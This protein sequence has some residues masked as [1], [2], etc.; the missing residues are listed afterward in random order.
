MQLV[1]FDPG[2]NSMAWSHGFR[3]GRVSNDSLAKTSSNS[4]R[5]SRTSASAFA[6]LCAA[7]ASLC[8]VVALAQ[9]CSIFGGRSTYSKWSPSVNASSGPR[10]T[11]LGLK[12][13]TDS[14]LKV[15][16]DSDLKVGMDSNLK[17]EQSWGSCQ[18]QGRSLLLILL[19][20][21]VGVG[22]SGTFV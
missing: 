12:V 18:D 15:G 9:M 2:S 13:G 20:K 16:M 7:S 6:Y 11:T 4:H 21:G 1:G 17:V 8:E 22:Q 5:Y 19:L 10:W 14:N 3:S